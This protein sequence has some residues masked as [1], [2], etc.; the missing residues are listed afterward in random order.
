MRRTKLDRFN[1]IESFLIR[2]Q[3]VP[4]GF[5]DS[6][7]GTRRVARLA[8]GKGFLTEYGRLDKDV[9]G[10]VDAAIAK[11][12][13]HPH[14]GSH[15]EKPKRSWDDRIRTL[16]V[17]NR[18][19]GIVLAPM[20]GDTYCLVTIL[21]KDKAKAYAT[22]HRFS[23]NPELGALEVR[24]EEAIQRL[25][26]QLQEASK[27]NGKRLFADVSDGELARLG[28]DAQ[29]LPT[30]RLMTS[31][32][33]LETRQ[34]ALPEAQYAALH[35]PARGM[36]LD[37]AR[38]EVARLYAAGTTPEQVDT[39]DL[40]SAMERSPSQVT[41]VAGHEELRLILAHP[42]AAWRMFLHPSQRKIAYRT[43]YSGPAQV[44]GGPGTGKT[45]T[46]L[47]R[48]AFLAARA[49]IRPASESG[50]HPAAP[51]AAQVLV[52]TFNGAL[53]AALGTQLDLLIKDD[54]ARRGI[55]VLNVDRLAYRIVMAARGA[56]VS[57]DQRQL[58]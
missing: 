38:K 14:P 33:D 21:P 4:S 45:V 22:S 5:W 39:D 42:F 32:A 25:Q 12:A 56:A 8:I 26:L 55:E 54:R 36:G 53:A 15:L 48:A 16:E 10:A 3:V 50:A 31:E 58:R 27:P 19:R 52:T 11:F 30:I 49:A 18:W 43:S 2:S 44:T 6:D 24:D 37:E 1:L 23:V 7:R 46:L 40:V 47:R 35:A 13:K 34:A 28:V 17:D 9:Q 29:I 51:G 57:A 20:T 41:F